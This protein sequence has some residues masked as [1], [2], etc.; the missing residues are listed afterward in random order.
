MNAA[1]AHPVFTV[2]VPCGSRS[3]T[4]QFSRTKR[5]NPWSRLATTQPRVISARSWYLT[6][7]G[8]PLFRSLPFA[9]SFQQRSKLFF[10][11]SLSENPLFVLWNYSY[12]RW[13][14][15]R[16]SKKIFFSVLFGS[17]LID[18]MFEILYKALHRRGLHF[19]YGFYFIQYGQKKK[20][21]E[22]FAGSDSHWSVPPMFFLIL[23]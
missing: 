18:F 5:N 7:F 22:S 9:S 17:V 6:S 3:E 8:I 10:F 4:L 16:F 1:R 20:F 13:W 11:I 15:V 23:L 2:G 21:F 12:K 19:W 14:G